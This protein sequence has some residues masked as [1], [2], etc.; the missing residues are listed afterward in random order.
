MGVEVM[1]KLKLKLKQCFLFLQIALMEE[2]RFADA[3]ER[4]SAGCEGLF[5]KNFV[6]FRD[7]DIFAPLASSCSLLGQFGKPC[8]GKPVMV[9]RE[10]P[11]SLQAISERSCRF[12]KAS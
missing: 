1:Q 4:H 11:P 3:L 10:L 8:S 12:S 9:A 7:Q 2:V 5:R 6:H